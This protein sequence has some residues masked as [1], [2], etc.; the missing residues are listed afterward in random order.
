LQLALERA[1]E[2]GASGLRERAGE[3]ADTQP[4]DASGASAEA[5]PRLKNYRVLQKIGEG[6]CGAV[7]LADQLQPV[8][9][10][11]A[12]KIIK[13]GMDTRQVIARFEAERQALALMDHPNIAKV[14]DAGATETG[15]PYFV[16][17]L[18]RGIRITDYCDR[19]NLSTK[20]RLDLFVRVCHA[21]Q[22]AHQKGIIHRDI[23]PSN[24]LVTLQEDGTPAPKIIDFGIAKATAGR[25]LTDKTVFTAFEQF[26]GT[27]AYMSPE[28]AEM[29]AV[30]IDTRSDIYA[31]G[32]L[33]YELLTGKTPF[34][35][36]RLMKAGLDEIRRIIREEDPPR[37]S[38]R[39]STLEAAE[40]T[41]IAKCRRSEPPKLLG[42]IRGDLDWIVMKTLEKDRT[43]RYD[44]ANALASDIQCHLNHEPVAARPSGGLYRFQKLVRRNRLAFAA[45]SAVTVALVI[46]LGVSTWLFVRERQARQETETAR[47]NETKLRKRAEASEKSALTQAERAEAAATETKMT[48]ASSDFLQAIRLISEEKRGAALAYLGRSL[49]ANPTN[50]AALTRLATLLTYHSWTFPT[51]IL[52]HS[53]HVYCAQFSPDGK[54][55][56]TASHDGTVRVWDAQSGQPLTEPMK[57]GAPVNSAQFSPDGKRI[58]TA[59]DDNTARVWDAQS[60]QP[61]TEP[62][63]HGALVNS[64]QF[65]PDGK[66]IVTASDD[67]TARVWDAQSGQLLT[68][69]IKH[70]ALVNSAQFSPDGKRIVTASRDG[71][72]R[73]WDAQGGQPLTA[74]MRHGG[75]VRY[76]QFSPDGSRIVTA[77]GDGTA[78]VWDAQSGQPLTEPFKHSHWV[79]SAQFSPDGKRIVTASLDGTARVWDAQSGQPLTAPMKHAGQV[80]SAQFSPDGKRIVT[81]SYDSTARVWDAQSGQPLTEP[82]KHGHVYSAQFSPDGKRIVTASHDS[83]ARVWDAQSGQPLTAHMKHGHPVLCARFSPEGRRIVT[84]SRDQTARVW[85]ARSGQPLTEPLEHGNA[86]RSA[87]FS[88]DGKRIVTASWDDAARVWDAQSGQLLAELVK[89]G[90]GVNS[91]QFSP[92]GERVVTASQ[93]GT[94]RV[95]DIAPCQV[96]RRDWVL[97][98]SEVISGQVLNKQGALEET[99]LA[100]PET[101]KQ[102]REK[103]SHESG[104]DDWVVWGRWFLADP[105]TRAISPF[106]KITV[107]QYIGNRIKENTAESLAEAEQLA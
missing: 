53:S 67:N 33:L 92:D 50:D 44:T 106:S 4:D 35:A 84:A 75:S 46:G 12:V 3:P 31:L 41:T 25:T 87:Q 107:P 83:T 23:K 93:D 71:T 89:H 77:S 60:G 29:M 74:P 7:Y 45:A 78:R 30:D 34:E 49:A 27:P 95:W 79:M 64:A 20:Q 13:L 22:H 10:R 65:S 80:P 2:E 18:V 98:L 72:A 90:G 36:R 58:V 16:M 38:A 81:A 104:D 86:V 61:L 47:A 76:A 54:L 57:H 43:R 68:E 17:E 51:L 105:R 94:A 37:P 15:R 40:Q 6:G 85:D 100:R 26:I 11:V 88:P 24:I 96:E 99:R 32:V 1:A 82:M 101:I 19:N 55:I 39:I 62:I 5:L 103:L 70:G 63:R 9:R 102:I 21:I 59:S 69:P 66:R 42:L 48:L 14:L 56:V 91:A 97:Q 8:R 28:Q 73:V 52:K